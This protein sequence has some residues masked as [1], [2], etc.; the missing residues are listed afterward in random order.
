[1]IT[2]DDHLF[3]NNVCNVLLAA[4]QDLDAD[5]TVLQRPLRLTDPAQSVSVYGAYWSPDSQSWET[6]HGM[7]GEPT[8]SRYT[9][10]IQG[11]IR[12]MDVE[13]GLQVHAAL[14]AKIR[15]ML[16][17]N[18]DVKGALGALTATLEGA[19]ERL[20]RW[21]VSNQDLMQT[22]V[23]SGWAFLSVTHIVVE[24]AL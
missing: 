4:L 13:R 19:T 18:T 6:G 7:P 14:S 8:I 17:R 23:K 22:Q 15:A 5:L 20:T 12:D 21:K 24:T 9:I 11:L 1:M 2:A 3:P 10:T 16:V